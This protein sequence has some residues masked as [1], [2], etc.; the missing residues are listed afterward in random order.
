MGPNE[1]HD[2]QAFQR[3]E[4]L[5]H[6]ALEQPADER[7]TFLDEA[8]GANETL[9]RELDRLLTGH[10]GSSHFM[11]EPVWGLEVRIPTPESLET[12]LHPGDRVGQYRLAQPLG[13]GGMGAI[14]L[15]ERNDEQFR[16]QVALKIIKR[17]MDTDEILRRFRR[18]RQVLAGLAHPNIARLLDGGATDDGRPFFVMEYVEGLRIDQHCDRMKLDHRH[19]IQL[20]LQV[21]SAV[22]YAHQRLIIHRDLKP[23]NILISRD[24]VPKLL[25][26]GI[27]KVLRAD[28]DADTVSQTAPQRHILTPR[29]A[30]PEQIRGTGVT[31][32]SDVYSLGVVLHE[33]LTG[34]APY[35][36]SGSSRNE[37][38]RA[39]LNID[40]IR[41][42]AIRAGLNPELDAIVLKALAK[43][44][45]DRYPSVDALAA[46]LER[47]LAGAPVQA[48]PPSTLYQLG[49]LIKQH[50]LPFAFVTTV[51]G[52]VLAFALV[53]GI[54]AFR[55]DKEQAAA[56]RRFGEVR[57][58]A[59]KMIYDLH[60]SILPVEGTLAARELIVETGLHYLDALA[61]EAGDDRTLQLECALGYFRIAEIQGGS[62]GES[63]GQTEAALEA[64]RKGLAIVNQ[65]LAADPDKGP[66][67]RGSAFGNL[68]MGHL[69]GVIGDTA[70]AE[71]SFERAIAL[72]RRVVASDPAE[73]WKHPG[74]DKIH[75]DFATFL[76]G[77]GRYDAA[78]RHLEHAIRFIEERLKLESD[79][80]LFEVKL[81]NALAALGHNRVQRGAF[82]AARQPLES[83][84]GLLQD[85][86]AVP[87]ENANRWRSL[88]VAK[89]ALGRVCAAAGD[90]SG[91]QV[92][93]E[94]AIAEHNAM[95]A[96]D[97]TDVTAR[98]D[99]SAAHLF[100][101]KLLEDGGGTD[102]A[103]VQYRKMLEI[104]R[105]LANADPASAAAKRGLAVALDTT[106]ATLR[107]LGR[108]DDAMELNLAANAIFG[109]LA[110]NDPDNPRHQRSLAIS[111]FFLGKLHTELA[112][113]ARGSAQREDRLR[114]ALGY[115][116]ESSEIMVRMRDADLLLAH[117][118]DVI[119]MLANEIDSCESALDEPRP[120]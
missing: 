34:Q 109:E 36:L 115:F 10:D 7:T 51:F 18:E 29:Y 119:E 44:S 90:S 30:S 96:A 53:A 8:C 4:T 102:A 39:V 97:P 77:M 11:S 6:A 91:A 20:F 120:D 27:A 73:G 41:P 74:L 114:S 49:K 116:R 100:L 93:F 50:R 83:A 26:F 13:A 56:E 55:L 87:H 117:E 94:W 25:D 110:A 99:L 89:T 24:G 57:G 65:R 38:E 101:G 33:L 86:T 23:G 76:E 62:I 15:A 104:R 5:F 71:N 80:A 59:Q 2:K 35:R 14:W 118:G 60:D 1:T 45:A 22:R 48:H 88:I 52:L 9:R 40:P 42:S 81:G 61:Q 21:C 103:L 68:L 43:D 98:R 17:G 46:D 70:Q 58:L 63:M 84:I 112:Q 108:L 107:Q 79:N 3:L 37:I 78:E 72:Q 95:I 64:C 32:A 67:L 28:D 92:A 113:D 16:H 111:A 85:A 69:L 19:R 75:A 31:T 106:G 47:Y 54:L 82:E 105:Q 12:D 66:L